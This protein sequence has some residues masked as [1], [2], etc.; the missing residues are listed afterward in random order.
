M[1][2]SSIVQVAFEVGLV[3]LYLASVAYTMVGS[4]WYVC[5]SK[6]SHSGLSRL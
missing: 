3:V 6:S 1:N 2:Y 5:R 4:N